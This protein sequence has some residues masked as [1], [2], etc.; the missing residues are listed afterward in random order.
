MYSGFFKLTNIS[1]LNFGVEAIAIISEV[2]AEAANSSELI[3]CNYEDL[4]HPLQIPESKRSDV[5]CNGA[6]NCLNKV[7]IYL[8]SQELLH[9]TGENSQII[10]FCFPLQ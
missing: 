6:V 4:L 2:F 5:F 10:Q 3:A 8:I 9:V 1:L 7:I